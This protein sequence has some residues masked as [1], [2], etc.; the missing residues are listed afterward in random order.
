MKRFRLTPHRL[1]IF[2][3]WAFYIGAY[4]VPLGCREMFRPD[5]FRY[6]EIPRE[7]LRSGDWITPRLVGFRYFEK[8]ALGYQIV[9]A[10]FRL[11]GENAFA[12]RLPFALATGLTALMLYALVRRWNRRGE[13]SALS[14]LAYL[15]SGLVFGVGTYGVL[16]ALL[17]MFLTASLAAFLCAWNAPLKRRPWWLLAAGAAAGGAF[18]VK[19]FLALAIPCIVIA[20]FLLW[21]REWKRLFTL[22]WLPL[23]V[24]LAVALPWSLAIAR[25]EPD[26]WN[27]FFFEEHVKRFFSSTYD[28]KPQPVWFFLPILA[29]GIW[30]AGLL[31]FTAW[32]GWTR[33]FFRSPRMRYLLLWAGVPFLFFSA[34]SCKL[35]TYILPCFPPL[36]ALIGCGLAEALR[37][38]PVSSRRT[39]RR[40]FRI[41]GWAVIVAAILAAAGL[42]AVR[43]MPQIPE[44]YAA[45]EIVWPL[46]ALAGLALWG[47]GLIRCRGICRFAWFGL[48]LIPAVVCGV[49]AVPLAIL[50]AT[51]TRIGIERCLAEMPLAPGDRLFSDRSTAQPLA[52]LTDRRDLVIVGK[53]GEFAYAMAHDPAA[54]ARHCENADLPARIAAE[55]GRVMLFLIRDLRKKPLPASW[56]PDAVVTHRGVV[57][58]CFDNP[59]VP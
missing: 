16:D 18:L 44:L 23:A 2:S 4:L 54:R 55:P 26:F 21:Q 24:A 20:P 32:R 28:R 34:S 57:L 58:C 27:Y 11:F 17:T 56:H 5:E 22:P 35:G 8:P 1:L 33:R 46:A 50:K 13:A 31:I 41:A 30:P 9:A 25:A 12:L 39:L 19:G 36:A 37:S 51:P 52:W 29:A 10:S 7:M 38:A 3:L 48:G 53:Q 42:A 59:P 45:S 49:N 14:V 15:A 40:S 47:A 43:R 6:A